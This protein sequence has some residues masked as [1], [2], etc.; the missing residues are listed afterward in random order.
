MASNTIR[1]DIYAI[2]K[3]TH[4]DFRKKLQTD[5]G[6]TNFGHVDLASPSKYLSDLILTFPAE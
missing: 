1:I 3:Y 5:I 4:L 6:V 2:S